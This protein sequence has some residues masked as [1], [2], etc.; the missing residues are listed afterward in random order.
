MSQEMNYQMVM[1]V[2]EAN[3]FQQK[4]GPVIAQ[5]MTSAPAHMVAGV[6]KCCKKK[7]VKSKNLLAPTEM[8]VIQSDYDKHLSII[9]QYNVGEVEQ[10]KV[11]AIATLVKSQDNLLVSEPEVVANKIQRIISSTTIQEVKQEI[12]A[13]FSEIKTQHSN[14][15]TSKVS[16]AV[17]ESAIAI[18]FKKISIQEPHIGLIRV[19]ATNQNGQNLIAEIQSEKQVDIRTELV[20]YNDGSCKT[21]I[22][23]FDEELVTRGITTEKKEQKPTYGVP[24]LP[25]AKRILQSRTLKQRTFIDEP[26]SLEN[27]NKNIIT[28][29]HY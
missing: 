4:F 7:R 2:R 3:N 20:G 15:F 28:I 21:V 6:K 11:A 18:G 16:E 9:K 24:R 29:N 5:V 12:K 22:R 26:T 19:V 14:T 25:Y 10:L 27:D 17:K 13:T 8:R 1:T 23:R